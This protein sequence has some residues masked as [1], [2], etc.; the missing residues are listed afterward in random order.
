MVRSRFVSE[1]GVKVNPRFREAGIVRLRTVQVSNDVGM[2]E[3]EELL[4]MRKNGLVVEVY[5]VDSG[6]RLDI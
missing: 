6:D 2:R 1:D 3:I 5:D 4:D